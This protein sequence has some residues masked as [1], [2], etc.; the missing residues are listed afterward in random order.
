MSLSKEIYLTISGY[1]IK[2]SD[3]LTF[4]KNDQLKL[5]F[6]INEYGIDVEQHPNTRT[7]MPVNPLKAILFI[8]N[9]DGVDSVSS[10]KIEGNAVTFYLEEEHTQ[11]VGVSR[12]QIRLFDQ[13]GC[14]VTLPH[15]TF[16]IRE[17]IYG[18]DDIKFKNV[19]LIDKDGSA[20]VTEGGQ[21]LDVGDLMLM[22]VEAIYPESQ[23]EISSLPYKGEFNGAE[24]LLVQD[25]EGA[26]QIRLQK[27]VDTLHSIGLS[28][29]ARSGN[30]E[31]LTNKPN[32]S[33]YATTQNLETK[34]D[35]VSGKGLST[36]D[37]TNADMEKLRSL[38]N[39]DVNKA[40]V[41]AQLVKKANA[42]H[43]HSEYLT[44]HQDISGKVNRTELATVA[45]SGSYNDL[46]NKPTIP[47]VSNFATMDYVNNQL[48]NINLSSYQRHT[49]SGLQ[50]SNKTIVGAINELYAL[51]Q[52]NGG[53]GGGGS[54]ATYGEIILSKTSSSITAGNSDTFTVRLDKQPTSNQTITISV[55]NSYVNV[56]PSILTFTPSN[57]NINQ[58]VT[59][60]GVSSG[61]STITLSSPNVSSKTISVS[62]SAPIVTYGEIV[63]NKTNMNVQETNRGTFTVKLSK[64]PSSNQTVTISRSNSNIGINLTQ[65]TFTPSNWNIEQ[66]VIVSGVSSGNTTITV[67]SNGVS[68]QTINVTIASSAVSYSE[69]IVSK[70]YATVQRGNTSNFTVKLASAPS[71]N[72]TVTIHNTNSAVSV[73]PSYLTFTS[74]NWNNPQTITVTGSTV[75]GSTLTLSSTNVDSK[76]VS[77]GVVDFNISGTGGSL[78]S[79]SISID[80]VSGVSVDT[81]RGVDVSSIIALENSGVS[82]YNSNGT[83]QDIFK[84][85]SESGVNYIRVR[86]WNNPFNSNGNGY[87]GGNNDINTA[88]QIGQRATQYGMRLL[89]DFHYSDFWADPDK[90]KAPKA[91][92]SYSVSQKTDAIYNFTK[93]SLQ[94]LKDANV[95]VGMVQIGNETGYGFVGCKTYATE[96][97]QTVSFS[98]IAKMMN[99][100]SRA[101][102][103]I[104]SNILVAVHNTNPENGYTYIAQ[105]YYNN[106]VDYDV[107]ASSYYPYWHGTL[108]NLTN[109]LRNIANTYNKKV[110]VAETSYLYTSEDGDGH[111]NT[112]SDNSL[113]PS[114]PVSIQGQAKHVRDVFEAVANVGDKG[115]GVFYWEPAWIPVGPSSQYENNK[116]LWERYGSGWASSYANEYDPNDAGVYYGGSAVDNQ[117]MFD[118]NG[119]ALESL[120]VFKY[121]IT[122]ATANGSGSGG[123]GDNGSGGGGSSDTDILEMP[124]NELRNKVPYLSTYYVE[125]TI[126]TGQNL[127]LKFFVTDFYGRSYTMNSDFYRYKVIVK[128][129][130]KADQVLTNLSAGEHTVTVGSFSSEGTYHYSII[131]RDQY[132][133]YSHELF[134][135]VR[136]KNNT[137]HTNV[138]TVTASDL[139][140]YGITYNQNREQKQY[141][142]VSSANGNADSINSLVQ[143][144]YDSASVPSGKYLCLIPVR[145]GSSNYQGVNKDWDKVKV[146]YASDYNKT[147]V[148]SECA[149][150]SVKLTQLLKD[151]V[152]AG[153]NKI[154]M[155][156]ATYVVDE[157]GFDIPSG[158]DFDMNGATFKTNPFTG[159][160]AL[161]AKMTDAIDTHVHNGTFEGD[162]FAHDYANS[163]NNSEWVSGFE[164]GGSCRYSS[165]YDV[166]IK[167]ITGYGLQ[168]SISS[169]SSNGTTFFPPVVVGDKTSGFE[170]GD[171]DTTTGQDKTCSYRTRTK[172]FTNISG[173]IGKSDFLTVSIHLN[174]QGNEFDSFN[175]VVYFYDSGRNFIEAVNAYQYR[176]VKIPQGAYYARTVFLGLRVKSDWNVHY[177][178]LR[179]PTHCKFENVT[180][181][182]ARCVGMA[183]GQMKDFLVKDCTITNSGQSSATCAYDAEDGWDG[184]QDAFFENFNLTNNP[185][186]G[187]LMCAG[188]NFV[189]N[190]MTSDGIYA[191]DRV[192][193]LEVK[194]SQF[195]SAIIRSG[196]E[197]NIKEH[198]VARFYN[199]TITGL[200]HN[201][202]LFSNI[203]KN[204]QFTNATPQN[205]IFINS[206]IQGTRYD[207]KVIDN[208][209]NNPCLDDYGTLENMDNNGSSGGG[210]NGGTGGD[211]STTY[212]EIVV[213]STSL[214]VTSGNST[215]FTVKLSKQ[216][217]TNQT[218]SISVSGNATVS[219]SSLTFTSS[220]WNNTQTVT[221]NGTSQGSA[222]ITL[223]SSGVS[224]KQISVN[225]TSSGSGGGGT[226]GATITPSSATIAVNNTQ[227]FTLSGT[228][229]TIQTAY[230]ANSKCIIYSQ[231][232]TSVTIQAKGE[233]ADY[234]NIVLSDSTSF[235]IPLTIT[236]SGSGGDSGG[237]G[238][239]TTYG[240]IVT[241]TSSLSVQSGSSTTFTV[242]LSQAPSSSQTVYISGGSGISVSPTSLTFSSSNWNSN[243]TVTVQGTA[244]GSSSITLSSTNVSS[245]TIN[246]TVTS[247]STGGGG[248]TGG[249]NSETDSNGLVI[250]KYPASKKS[251]PT[252]WG[253]L[254]D[255]ITAGAGAGGSSYS[256]ANVAAKAIGANIHNHGISGSCIND[257]YNLALT[258]PGYED[259]FCNRYTQMANGLDL[260]T[261]FGSVNDHRADSKLGV[262]G[263]TDSKDF[264]G[265]LHVLITGL[266]QKYP[267]SRI[268]FITPFKI[269]GYEGSNMYGHTL[270][271]FRNAIVTMCNKHQ[272][273]V[274]DLFTVEE[275]NWLKGLHSGYFVAYDY[276][277]PT[278][279]GHQAIA[280]YLVEQ[281]FGGSGSG[282]GGNSGSGGNNGSGGGG[283]SESPTLSPS[284]A[285]INVGSTQTFNVSG[286]SS[287]ISNAYVSS[288]CATISSQSSTSVTVRG[289]SS[290]TDYL[291]I[292]LSNGKT[293]SGTIY[294]N[295][296]SGGGSGG[297]S[298]NSDISNASETPVSQQYSSSH[299]ATPNNP[300]PPEGAYNWV[301]GPRINPDGSFPV[302]SWNAIGHWMTTYKVSGSSYYDNVGLLLQNPK[303]WIW[304]ASTRS[305]D[306]LSE[307]FEWGTWYREDFWDDGNG[308]ISG[309]TEWETGVSGNHSKWVKIK[310]TSETSGRCFHPWGYQKNWRSNSNWLNNGQPYIV[311]K[312]DF[313]LVKWNESGAD[314]LD[315]A[316]L[317]VNSGADWWSEVGATW[318]P[319]WSTNRDM[320]VGKYILATRQLKRAWCTNV[321]SNWSYGFPTDSSDSGS[322]GGSGGSS[323]G[324]SSTIEGLVSIQ[325]PA[326]KQNTTGEWVA[327][328]N[329]ITYGYQV[330]GNASAYPARVASASSL[331]ANNY[332]ESGRVV[333]TGASGATVPD[334]RS[335]CNYYTSLPSD[336]SL[337]TVFGGVNDFLLGVSLGSSSSTDKSTFYGALNVLADGLKSKYPSSRITFFTPIRIGGHAT[338][339]KSGHTLKDYRNAIVTVCNNKGLEVLDLYSLDSMDANQSVSNYMGTWD[340]T[341]PNGNGHQTI[342]D[343]MVQQMLN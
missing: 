180:I 340:T 302:S 197:R 283:S 153:Y 239:S 158:L 271:D 213:S 40:Y 136:V 297:G 305:W 21:M 253:A 135:Y 14:V 37:Y 101:V 291:N 170:L 12:M 70:T 177:H 299:E 92:Q 126:S 20:I 206:T 159:N 277:H 258:E 154:V 298:N 18:D 250:I 137:A 331:R 262:D 198:G 218:V 233:G 223:S 149:N 2:L 189:V 86:V 273:E 255:S 26:K 318:Q 190:N 313:K 19:V 236:A 95:H 244:Q 120:N 15:F 130:G 38:T 284:S 200:P 208:D 88:I 261:V 27:L 68:S 243:Q 224:S 167:D 319:D 73:S 265:A 3:N 317:V 288:G 245:Q 63:L 43:T 75:G 97:Y 266:K 207:K 116:V 342:A 181:D 256:Y 45:T 16:E 123:S 238:S 235:S 229:A 322:S 324:G 221:I 186:N 139:S 118:F 267:T 127:T 187:F 220:N 67:S 150:N 84:T 278:V 341:H 156:K 133:R 182:N 217:S 80:K 54:S 202:Y 102:R 294:V 304:N 281:M 69:M 248:S 270:K 303:A 231:S 272:L 72:Q 48:S 204:C 169:K 174:Y 31:D 74:S 99:A 195:V 314:N 51:L 237:G 219:P 215:T 129:D 124:D 310:Q 193:W 165:V 276:Y 10:A 212:G 330:G 287:T 199:N 185:H 17:N 282:N 201:M 329:S 327:F 176:Q 32:L 311:T 259:A 269:G 109:E 293:L 295:S 192:R 252:Y 56:N 47:N 146:K 175:M 300:N 268:V 242:R 55:N 119:K 71:G 285:T 89:V 343:Y 339:N 52:N 246:V 289:V 147:A 183:Q 28:D 122:G 36:N 325:Y 114:Y 49:D 82:F 194:N 210:S 98:D 275:F 142:N 338:A 257:G 23:K 79:P 41:D 160:G 290:G 323:G 106:G 111:H 184:M 307:D 162:Y 263:S 144:A 110:M 66:T 286:T 172:E 222:T 100:G 140:S 34:V 134:N 321:P 143:S 205:G 13:D 336:A 6:C 320:A 64:Q 234:L 87:G 29:V 77:V 44:E 57:W 8:E 121:I 214:S 53:S 315:N 335:F 42:S 59:L 173:A 161:I 138:Y 81:I 251:N 94:K 306:V 46:T 179:V 105:D 157:N 166:T 247:S 191:W 151:K 24:R 164:M 280:N 115:I 83:R 25:E 168:N 11:F 90:Q 112:V 9:P 85:L 108:S 226:G 240:E 1:D 227:T 131:A 328:G 211:G 316:R 128:C 76:Q 337:V 125:P 152:N 58:T 104:D 163:T 333:A 5:V 312:I 113:T 326:T 274:L 332:G 60:N 232:P 334:A 279:Q 254:G 148:A 292:T 216:P 91:W 301:N 155:Y 61:S 225:V 65:L 50:T 296:S 4:Y 35:K 117:A 132:G 7:L 228:S 309:T 145:D 93:E 260:V 209:I 33:I 39:S 78:T 96:G 203:I 30:Y 62:V 188:H 107:F 241:S 264:F 196:G 249:S 171:I 230:L 308:S 103:E 141:V 178:F 22:G